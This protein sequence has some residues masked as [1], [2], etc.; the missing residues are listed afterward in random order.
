M[1]LLVRIRHLSFGH[2]LLY[3]FAHRAHSALRYKMCREDLKELY[4]HEMGT[5]DF[6]PNV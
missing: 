5:R 6:V 4:G 3:A 1:L 2:R